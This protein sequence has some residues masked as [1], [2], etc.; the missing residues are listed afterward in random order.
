MAVKGAVGGDVGQLESLAEVFGS[1]SFQLQQTARD[2]SLVLQDLAT[3]GS[4]GIG[5]VVDHGSTVAQHGSSMERL[6]GRAKRQASQLRWADNGSATGAGV[7]RGEVGVT[8]GRATARQSTRV[9]GPPMPRRVVSRP[10]NWAG[11]DPVMIS[12]GQILVKSLR[13]NVEASDLSDAQVTLIAAWWWDANQNEDHVA[14]R[15]LVAGLSLPDLERLRGAVAI[16]DWKAFG[17]VSRLVPPQL[18]SVMTFLASDVSAKLTNR[19]LTAE[20]QRRLK[21]SDEVVLD[22]IKTY[23]R[24]EVGTYRHTLDA[25]AESNGRL[26]WGWGLPGLT[27]M[28]WAQSLA[29]DGDGIRADVPESVNTKAVVIAG[30]LEG[31]VF[32]DANRRLATVRPEATGGG[33]AFAILAGLATAA[34]IAAALPE[35]AMAGTL[36]TG[37]EALGLSE[38][39]AALAGG[40]LATAMTGALT[41]LAA[42]VTTRAVDAVAGKIP[43]SDVLDPGATA[44]DV[45]LGGLLNVA[46]YGLVKAIGKVTAKIAA[47]QRAG[48]SVAELEHD[49]GVLTKGLARTEAAERELAATEAAKATGGSGTAGAADDATAAAGGTTRVF[50]VEASGNL[51]VAIGSDGSVVV[52][53]GKRTLFLNFGDEARA[54][55]FCQQRLANPNT[56]MPEL[57]SFEVPNSFVEAIK[58]QAVPERLARQFPHAPIQVDLSKTATSFGLRPEQVAGLKCVIIPGSGKVTC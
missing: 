7:A 19:E 48:K 55:E 31:K 35:V 18:E 44:R 29:L 25:H 14:I 47:A 13:G 53:G 5:E 11:I 58:R 34:L 20:V 27:P 23:I 12:A 1:W 40:V 8:P 28:W 46:R 41:G 16:F 17:T 9:Y 49:L 52:S 39:T 56:P 43:W 26:I 45:V 6:S 42:G 15:R 24:Y 50:R 21:V 36:A 54:I 57:K 32:G 4:E 38:V 33:R 51:R 30:L 22:A 10:G 37:L 3:S 2:V